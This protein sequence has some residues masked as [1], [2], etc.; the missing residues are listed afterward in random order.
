MVVYRSVNITLAERFT[1]NLRDV[2]I[3]TGEFAIVCFLRNVV[4][5]A[6]WIEHMLCD[7]K[8]ALEN[9]MIIIFNEYTHGFL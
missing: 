6:K 8:M 9:L 5:K 2:F 3:V 7:F 1:A 4:R